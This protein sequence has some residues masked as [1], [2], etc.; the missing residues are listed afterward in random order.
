MPKQEQPKDRLLTVN[1]VAERWSTPVAYPR[2]LIQ[3]RRIT[4]VRIG[5]HVR[6]P[7]SV[8]DSWIS[9]GTVE[10]IVRPRRRTVA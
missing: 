6:I 4:F 1:E 5:R 9:E 10:A 2:R 7:E 8:V 3:E